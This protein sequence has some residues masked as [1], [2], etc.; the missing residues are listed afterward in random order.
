MNIVAHNLQGMFSNRQL[1]IVNNRK[2]KSIEKLSS[3]YRINR[4]ADDAAGLAISEKMRRQIRGLTQGTKNTQD[5]ISMCQIADG[6]LAE[7]SDMMHRLTELSVKS[8]NGT[9]DAQDRQAIQQ[10]VKDLL[11]EIDRVSETTVFNEQKIFADSIE[12]SNESDA[13]GEASSKAYMPAKGYCIASD[14]TVTFVDEGTELDDSFKY[15]LDAKVDSITQTDDIKK[16]IAKQDFVIANDSCPYYWQESGVHKYYSIQIR[17]GEEVPDYLS[18]SIKKAF[19][20][21]ED[22]LEKEKTIEYKDKIFTKVEMTFLGTESEPLL[23]SVDAN[24]V[25]NGKDGGYK[26]LTGGTDSMGRFELNS[27]PLSGIGAAKVFQGSV[28]DYKSLC[29][30]KTESGIVS[31]QDVTVLNKSDGIITKLSA[32]TDLTGYVKLNGTGDGDYAVI[33]PNPVDG[34]SRYDEVIGKKKFW[35]QS[36][37]ESGDGIWLMFGNMNTST[38]GIKDLD[39]STQTGAHNSIERVKNGLGKLSSI[40]SEIG[41]QQN[42]LEHTIKHQ[43][44][45]IE[46]TQQAESLIRDSDMASEMI[47]FSSANIISQAGQAMLT[48]ANQSNQGVLTLLQ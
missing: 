12:N 43:E 37:A 9:N 17:A 31:D 30:E 24:K 46:N 27:S 41:A 21:A 26:F 36:G 7:V 28:S 1:G 2:E 18:S 35:I 13:E 6:A 39:V 15:Y 8:A 44:N 47:N 23:Y 34:E 11:K 48:Q 20:N 33:N 38:L 3:G 29:E 4:S 5:G 45:T 14:G 22:G 42:R 40:R 16:Y 25:I 32:G 19:I 10:E